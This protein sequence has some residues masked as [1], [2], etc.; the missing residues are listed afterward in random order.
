MRSK[1]LRPYVPAE[2]DVDVGTIRARLS[3]HD[4]HL[5]AERNTYQDDPHV[6][7]EDVRQL[8]TEIKRLEYGIALLEESR[9]GW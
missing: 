4:S 5:G 9:D 7:V 6:A 3:A 1:Q 2:P 8:L